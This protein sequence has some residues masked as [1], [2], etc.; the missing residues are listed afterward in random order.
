[1]ERSRPDTVVKRQRQILVSV[2]ITVLQSSQ[3]PV[4]AQYLVPSSQGAYGYQPYA[5]SYPSNNVSFNGG[6]SGLN[7]QAQ[8]MPQSQV[9][10]ARRPSANTSTMASLEQKLNAVDTSSNWS[11]VPVS[12][13][14]QP[15]ASA[16]RRPPM[17]ASGAAPGP[18]QGMFPGVSRQE[19]LRVFL[20]GGTPQPTGRSGM[21]A[22]RGGPAAGSSAN[23]STAY[24]NY[25]TAR[26]EASK[27]RNEANTARYNKDKWVRKNAA[28]RAE[29]AANNA[30][31]AAERAEAAAY[32]GD[33]QA[34]SYSGLARQS[35][36]EARANANR[37]RYNADTIQ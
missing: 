32:S 22:K 6:F 24:S 9:P 27:A 7:R 4:F 30:N 11:R 35:A 5:S 19:M 18:V 17:Q 1:M 34:R 21:T 25:Q 14:P 15:Q 31:Y 16:Q 3:V 20:E 2:G 8:P 36:N 26:N 23:T 28:S 29:Y 10:R 12:G 13:T 37:A 33:S